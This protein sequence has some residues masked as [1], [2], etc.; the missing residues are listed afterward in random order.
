L[1][2]L[3]SKKIKLT[4][5]DLL[6]NPLGKNSAYGFSRNKIRDDLKIRFHQLIYW[7]HKFDYK[8][9]KLNESYFFHFKIPSEKFRKDESF[10]Y[11][12][13]LEFYPDDKESLKDKNITN[14]Y[15]RVF[16]NSPAFMF[17]Y[18]YVC[19]H[20]D[21]IPKQLLPLC[22]KIAL[23]EAPSERN[24]SETYGYEKS[25][26]FACLYI[27]ETELYKKFKI[28]KE[29]YEFDKNV[30]LKEVMTQEKKLDEYNQKKGYIKKEKIKKKVNLIQKYHN[31]VNKNKKKK[32][33]KKKTK[34]K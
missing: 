22:S 9:Y 4:I 24:P 10:R 11:D 18:T 16:S 1:D 32:T 5:H 21:M 25:I 14:Y 12:V 30:F 20:N 17:T 33:I 23:K 15:L 29:L 27:M 3:N 6:T 31:Q 34:R 26:Y 8:V 13:V 2:I 19:Y 28:D 7:T